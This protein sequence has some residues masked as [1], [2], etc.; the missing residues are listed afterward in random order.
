MAEPVERKA[1]S[2]IDDILDFWFGGPQ[3]GG[4]RKVWWKK[5][6][7]FDAKVERRFHADYTEAA[8]GR[9]E[10]WREAPRNC[11]ALIL[12]LD[13]FPRNMFRG[14]ART[15]ATDGQ[16]LAAAKHAI[17]RGS[18]Q[19]LPPVE[20][21]FVYL[22]FE[23]S[24][25]LADQR[26]SIELFRGLGDDYSLDYAVRHLEIIERFGRFPHRNAILGRETTP[27]EAEFLTQRGSSF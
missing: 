17:E 4:D 22:P 12:L 15:Y 19:L 5:N 1:R 16:A 23:H 2:R 7:A 13:Q 10:G 8:A 20:R 3:H 26:R 14:E 18:D 6:P 24:E 21:Q 27:E 25:D 11:L 9:R